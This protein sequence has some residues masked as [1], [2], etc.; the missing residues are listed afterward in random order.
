MPAWLQQQ[1]AQPHHHPSDPQ[2]AA[3]RG[4]LHWL[5]DSSDARRAGARLHPLLRVRRDAYG[6]STTY[7][8]V[9]PLDILQQTADTQYQQVHSGT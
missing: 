4:L 6:E 5:R 1:P 2:L 8:C 7:A 9:L 3:A